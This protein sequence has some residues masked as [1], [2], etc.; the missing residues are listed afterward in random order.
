MFHLDEYVGMT[1]SHPASFR[2][3]NKSRLVD[4]VNPRTAHYLAG[5][6]ADLEIEMKRYGDLITA[7]P[8]DVAFVG[9]GENGHIAFN[10]PHVADFKDPQI[11]KRV[12]LDETCRRQ[13]VGE[14]HFQHIDSTPREALT[15]T[16]SALMSARTWI[17]CVPEARKARAV[18][19]SLESNI[20]TQCP[21]SLVRAHPLAFLYL[22]AQ[23]ACEL[24][25][26]G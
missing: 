7:A 3:W 12:L 18:K 13:Q 23:S 25:V 16:C 11:V 9:F 19:A 17:C 14:G 26:I 5:D 20:S 15:L 1:D 24:S 6:A 22:D 21:A 2:R 4:K 10:D 8:I